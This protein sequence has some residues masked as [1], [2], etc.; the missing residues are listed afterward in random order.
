[1]AA[2]QCNLMDLS[3]KAKSF[4]C[5]KFVGQRREPHCAF[6][7]A[8]DLDGPYCVQE[9]AYKLRQAGLSCRWNR[10]SEQEGCDLLRQGMD[11]LST[12]SQVSFETTSCGHFS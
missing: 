6:D 5:W 11:S 7:I 12:A 9:V 4:V 3:D 2:L 8:I 1:M 10:I